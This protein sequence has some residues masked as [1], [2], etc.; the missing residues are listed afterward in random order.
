MTSSQ[1]QKWIPPLL[2]FAMT[3]VA[4]IFTSAMT[5]SVEQVRFV[6]ITAKLISSIWRAG[7]GF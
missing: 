7:M 6:Q 4:G 2:I 1:R 3:F 5:T